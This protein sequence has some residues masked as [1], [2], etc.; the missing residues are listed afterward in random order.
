M[1]SSSSTVKAGLAAACAGIVTLG[2]VTASP[3]EA[4]PVTA[5]TETYVVQLAA[6]V[7]PAVL[8]AET[9]PLIRQTAATSASPITEAVATVVG[10]GLGLAIAPVWYLALPI[11]VPLLIF[12]TLGFSA[13]NPN[14]PPLIDVV[15]NMLLAPFSIGH[16]LAYQLFGVWDTPEPTV[17]A[18]ASPTT[19]TGSGPAKPGL[20]RAALQHAGPKAVSVRTGKKTRAEATPARVHEKSATAAPASAKHAAA[21]TSG[22]KA[23]ARPGA[24]RHVSN[25]KG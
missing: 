14:Q 15:V 5:R 13:G 7:R 11:T 23:A 20:A 2:L 16:G 8:P 4:D 18:A 12:V 10:V 24:D 6:V 9:S 19:G 25:P 21:G 3:P 22:T 1:Y 17:A